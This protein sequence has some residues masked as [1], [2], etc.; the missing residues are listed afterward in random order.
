MT[1]IHKLPVEVLALCAAWLDVC[2][3][4]QLRS[5]CRY[6]FASIERFRPIWEDLHRR[7]IAL[8]PRVHQQHVTLPDI[9]RCAILS[10][11]LNVRWTT[12]N[13]TSSFSEP[14]TFP[15]H[16]STRCVV[17][18]PGTD[19]LFC[20]SESGNIFLDS[21]ASPFLE[22]EQA[23][24]SDF[25]IPLH[26]CTL[27]WSDSLGSYVL[28]VAMSQFDLFSRIIEAEVR[29]YRVDSISAALVLVAAQLLPGS[30]FSVTLQNDLMC[31]VL[32]RRVEPGG[33][34][35]YI[36]QLDFRGDPTISLITGTTIRI[37]K[38]FLCGI[39]PKYIATCV[40]RDILVIVNPHFG[41]STYNLPPFQQSWSTSSDDHAV[42]LDPMYFE[43][44]ADYSA[45]TTP[46]IS[47]V[48]SDQSRPGF[49]RCL[50]AAANGCWLLSLGN[51]LEVLR[52]ECAVGQ[53]AM[54]GSM[55]GFSAQSMP[56]GLLLHTYTYLTSRGIFDSGAVTVATSVVPVSL[57]LFSSLA[58][59]DVCGRI[60]I[61]LSNPSS[62][63]HFRYMDVL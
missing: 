44:C 16:P 37:D 42:F 35:V 63:P 22:P 43:E 41:I 48:V 32:C 56:Q 17:L 50:I 10:N 62:F 19:W 61:F 15:V 14:T 25:K 36:R 30:I 12:G 29:I 6:L 1:D 54:L 24:V 31:A 18:V 39:D 47:P 40:R 9:R 38:R 2:D 34:C 59:D 57:P 46:S 33:S 60:G 45:T 13:I 21:L 5:T 58:F 28:L 8:D 52:T 3:V 55:R 26:T 27:S 4:L 11:R 23:I 53:H 51:T 20:I 7:V 49:Q